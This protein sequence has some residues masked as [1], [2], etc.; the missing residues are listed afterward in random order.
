MGEGTAGSDAA[1]PKAPAAWDEEDAQH[2]DE[3]HSS[4]VDRELQKEE[5]TPNKKQAPDQDK[6]ST[7]GDASPKEEFPSHPGHSESGI[8]TTETELE[9]YILDS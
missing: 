8:F 6:L 5:S 1:K 7:N 3:L 9:R 2:S 4:T